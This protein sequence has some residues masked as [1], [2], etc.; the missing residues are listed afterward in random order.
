ME[1]S[2]YTLRITLHV[3]RITFHSPMKVFLFGFSCACS[4]CLLPF[5]PPAAYSQN[6]DAHNLL[7]FADS[8]FQEED[9]LNAIHEYRRYLFLYPKGDNRDFVQVRIAASYQNAGRLQTAIAAYQELI[10]AYP[11]SPLIE[12]ARSNIAQCQLLQGDKATAI[13]SLRQFLSDY[14]ESELA[15]RAQFIIGM[16]H[17][18]DKDW[19]RAAREWKQVSIRYSRTSFG[20]ISDQ[21][22]RLVQHGGALPHRS[23][24]VAGLLSA[25]VPGLGQTYSGG[26]SDGLRA[27]LAVGTTAGG[28][29]HYIDEER[30]E[31]AIPLG[32]IGLFVYLRNI[33]AGVQSAKTFNT[34]HERKFLDGLRARIYESNLF[35]A[36]DRQATDTALVFWHSRF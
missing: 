29:G 8:L 6:F 18:E 11:Q 23:P 35:G 26:F 16:T 4:L 22:L 12:R 28:I 34:Q 13:S 9:Y 14:P 17:M 30:Y 10:A 15:P 27:L 19:A 5:V 25:F 33:Y 1:E 32:V 7:A 24:T 3:S 31:V 2:E 36:L 20:E 21:L